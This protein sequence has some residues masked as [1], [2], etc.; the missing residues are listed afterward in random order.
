[1]T[2]LWGRE[3]LFTVRGYW[4]TII[5]F[6]FY[7]LAHVVELNPILAGFGDLRNPILLWVNLLPDWFSGIRVNNWSELYGL[8]LGAYPDC[9]R[10]HV[11]FYPNI[12]HFDIFNLDWT[13]FFGFLLFCFFL[14]LCS[15]LCLFGK[16]LYP[17]LGF[18][19]CFVSL[20]GLNNKRVFRWK[21]L[22][23]WFLYLL[24]AFRS[25]LDWLLRLVCLM[26]VI[27]GFD[28]L[29]LV[30]WFPAWDILML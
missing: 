28:L 29:H 14:I 15:L 21:G 26:T 6:Y 11:F 25:L 4:N 1:M 30:D 13:F 18:L 8:E 3:H 2:L 27:L 22:L 20:I 12:G 10:R 5:D 16:L 19:W 17:G 24:L 7:S 23:L 9:F